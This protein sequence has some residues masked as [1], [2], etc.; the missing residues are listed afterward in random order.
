MCDL[1]SSLCRT[2][3]KI[4]QNFQLVETTQIGQPFFSSH[5]KE[6][7]TT[8]F[9]GVLASLRQWHW[10]STF[11]LLYSEYRRRSR[12]IFGGAK[13]FCPNFPKLAYKFWA[14]N[15]PWRS[16]KTKKDTKTKKKSFNLSGAYLFWR[17]KSQIQ[18]YFIQFHLQV[19]KHPWQ[20]FLGFSPNFQGLSTNKNIWWCACTPRSYTTDSEHTIMVF[21]FRNVPLYDVTNDVTW[22]KF[23]IHCPTP[24]GKSNSR[25]QA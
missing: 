6:G 16:M 21:N 20:N 19:S 4:L 5:P 9:W 25:G 15:I 17:K 1:I 10:A 11:K 18:T 2:V 24:W 8:L 7:P 23:Q 14:S 12:Q 13:K 3:A 22:E